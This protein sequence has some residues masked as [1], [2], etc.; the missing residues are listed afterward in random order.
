MLLIKTLERCF[1]LKLEKDASDWKLRLNDT[2][3]DWNLR[4]LLI[5]T[6]DRFWMTLLLI[7]TWGWF[8]LD[9]DATS[10]K[11]LFS[12]ISVSHKIVKILIRQSQKIFWTFKFSEHSN[13]FR[14]FVNNWKFLWML[15]HIHSKSAAQIKVPYGY[16]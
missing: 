1:W 11:I 8:W 4:L 9:L 16:S 15:K 6:W 5:G 10:N 7:V 3:F 13:Y 12:A 2:D 14:I